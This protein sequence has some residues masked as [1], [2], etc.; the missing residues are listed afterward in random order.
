MRKFLK[1]TLWVMAFA[2]VLLVGIL[3]GQNSGPNETNSADVFSPPAVAASK[4]PVK[5]TPTAPVKAAPSKPTIKGDDIVH[6]GE[7]VPA[8][9]YRATKAVTTDQHC[10]WSINKTDNASDIDSIIANGL[11][12]GGRPQVTLKAGQWFSSDRCNDW[13]KK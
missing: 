5:T 12:S 10:Y 6:V 13:V 9:T 2:V 11:P 3:I 1:G 4:A 8:G 7:D